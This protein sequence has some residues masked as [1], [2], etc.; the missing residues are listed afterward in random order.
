MGP[1]LHAKKEQM[2][3]RTS[4]FMRLDFF[5]AFFV[6]AEEDINKFVRNYPFQKLIHKTCNLQKFDLKVQNAPQATMSWNKSA[7]CS[8]GI[9]PMF[10]FPPILCANSQ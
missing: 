7:E 5:H 1:F 4:E 10:S 3:A 8:R 6:E 2:D 9:C